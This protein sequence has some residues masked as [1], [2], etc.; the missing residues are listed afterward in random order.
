MKRRRIP[1]T[2]RTALFKLMGGICHMCSQPIKVES[3][4]AWDVSHVIPLELGGTDDE[5]NWDIAHRSCHR[6]H[7]AKVDQPNISRAKRREAIQLGSKAPSATPIPRRQKPV[8][9][10]TKPPVMRRP[11][12]VE[13]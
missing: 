12:F 1:T 8:K 3:G 10:I 7:T 9:L 2:E 11:M 13:E 4:E 6:Q 5:S